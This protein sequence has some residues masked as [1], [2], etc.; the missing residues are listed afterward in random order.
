MPSSVVDTNLIVRAIAGDHPDHSPR[1]RR[2]LAQLASG[3]ATATTCGA[4]IAE[5]VYVLASPRLYGLAR[6]EIERE[7]GIV[8]RLPGLDLP[9]KALYIDALALYAALPRLKFVDAVVAALARQHSAAVLSFDQRFDGVP[10][11]TRVEPDGE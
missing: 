4:V 3:T 9:N 8:I 10:S 5:A 1:A 7:L 6:P 11:I 2:F